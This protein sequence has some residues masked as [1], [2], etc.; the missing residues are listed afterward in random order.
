MQLDSDCTALKNI[1]PAS[2][3]SVN[4]FTSICCHGMKSSSK[5]HTLR[6]ATNNAPAMTVSV[7]FVYE[8]SQ[9]P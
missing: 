1:W 8:P 2:P 5:T 7:T 4:G 3:A 6:K 9:K